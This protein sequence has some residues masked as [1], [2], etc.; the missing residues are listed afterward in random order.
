MLENLSETAK[1]L[2][3]LVEI[4]G[5]LG[6]ITVL[7][8]ILLAILKRAAEIRL[9]RNYK[10][11]LEDWARSLISSEDRHPKELRDDE[12]RAECKIM[13][14]DA[15]FTPTEISGILDLAIIVAKATTVDVLDTRRT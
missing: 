3:P 1:A 14:Y 10:D 6:L 13:L 12:W 5:G 8:T 11:D 15:G 9:W 7:A 2:M 4:V